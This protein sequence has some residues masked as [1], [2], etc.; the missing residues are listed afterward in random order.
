MD[1]VSSKK[2]FSAKYFEVKKQEFVTPDGRKHIH[3]NVYRKPVSVIFPITQNYD[4]YLISQFR[5]F[6]NGRI[7]EVCAGHADEGESPLNA[8][9]RELKEET[10][11]IAGNWDK[12]MEVEMSAS[13]I[14]SPAHI[15]IARQLKFEDQNL[16]HDEEI[17]LVKISLD[18]AI[19]KV[20]SGE[21]KTGSTIIGILMID[22]LRR[23]GKL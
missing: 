7:L 6:F 3:D 13:V 22:K 18:E 23:E 12:I 11:I 16:D 5:E 9:K 2:V 1:H 17:S 15:F 8:A 20:V 10:G 14:K 21:I 4:L 19:E